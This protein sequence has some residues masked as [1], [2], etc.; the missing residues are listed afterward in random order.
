MGFLFP[1]VVAAAAVAAGVAYV[2]DCG[3][4]LFELDPAR[5]FYDVAELAAPAAQGLFLRL[6]V[7]A[8]E[9]WPVS[10]LLLAKIRS[11]SGFAHPR[12]LAATPALAALR[13][14]FYPARWP[15]PSDAVEAAM[16][17]EEP[18]QSTVD[19]FAASLAGAAA[20]AAG[21]HRPPTVADFAAAY[22]S[23]AATPT[24]V[25][26]RVLRRV[27]ESDAAA[28][29]LRAFVRCIADDAMAQALASE[30][31]HAAGRPLSVL[32]GVP[33]GVK[34]EFDVAAY[35]T[36]GGTSFLH[37]SP[38]KERD[39][40]VAARLRA[41]GAVIVGK[42][43]MVE[44]GMSPLGMNPWHG[45]G[46]NPHS[47][48]HLAGG[49]SS[50]SAAAVAAGLVPLAV[51]A[52]GGG[53]VRIPAA[54]CG[55]YGIKPTFGRV[56]ERGAMPLA[57]TVA[58]AGTMA[59]SAADLALAYLAVAGPDAGDPSSRFQPPPHVRG[60]ADGADLTGLTV[61]VYGEW[62]ER[63]AVPA[64]RAAFATFVA[65]LRARGAAVRED[66][67]VPELRAM[68][69][70][71][72]VAIA[73]EFAASLDGY[74]RG[75]HARD[76]SLGGRAVLAAA[77]SMTAADYMAAARVRTFAIDALDAI[78]DSGVDVLLTPA[79]GG[80]APAIPPGSEPDGFFDLEV[81][82]R[83]MRYAAVPNLTGHPAA[84]FPVAYEDGTGLPLAAQAVARH[85]HE[86][87]LLRVAR[88]SELD[89]EAR[90]G[91]R[92]PERFYDVLQRG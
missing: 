58:H 59:G 26:R 74:W 69:T 84:V 32:D 60:A 11:D 88:A 28:P 3:E 13:P 62:V 27:E 91:L 47:P 20:P 76:F 92:R 77:R 46:R 51:G 89:L 30:R 86:H 45:F 53:S 81:T 25:V 40:A 55:V 39:S 49:S 78:F 29:P 24:G 4:D 23:G 71:H 6:F 37:D 38:P 72:K 50:G 63:G 75:G 56:S 70:A 66:V 36:G 44:C 68:M 33:V 54:F 8:A 1:A 14:T 52:D 65:A 57:H 16:A 64:Q 42:T 18:A 80:P 79:T 17:A 43:S 12:R 21:D 34:D 5:P 83:A 87:T 67:R 10:R 48:A 15:L 2:A 19:G 35:P 90:G 61:G 9:T 82:E 41:L 73:S 85:W 31:R 7:A 22:R